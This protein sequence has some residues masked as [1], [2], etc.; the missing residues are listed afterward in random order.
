MDSEF[1]PNHLHA[2]LDGS[3]LTESEA[4][5]LRS[6]ILSLAPTACL[7]QPYGLDV[8]GVDEAMADQIIAK[9]DEIGSKRVERHNQRTT[10]NR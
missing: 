10:E 7:V 4:D 5:E 3:L 2:E 6:F 9:L 1:P 8:F